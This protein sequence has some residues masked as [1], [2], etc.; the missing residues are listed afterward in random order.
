MRKLPNSGFPSSCGSS[1][2]HGTVQRTDPTPPGI[3]TAE[4]TNPQIK[5]EMSWSLFQGSGTGNELWWPEEEPDELI[6]NAAGAGAAG[7]QS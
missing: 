4:A 1:H 6:A 2:R 7:R 3:F 5:A